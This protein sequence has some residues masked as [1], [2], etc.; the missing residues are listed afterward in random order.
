M[1]FSSHDLKY[2]PTLSWCTAYASHQY[3]IQHGGTSGNLERQLITNDCIMLCCIISY[4][5]LYVILY[6]ILLHIYE[7]PVAM[8]IG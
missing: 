4:Y 1:Y 3:L 2:V 7:F 8:R 6:Y 5:I